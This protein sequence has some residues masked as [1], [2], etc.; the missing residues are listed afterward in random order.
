MKKSIFESFCI[1]VQKGM[2]LLLAN[3]PWI[4]WGC[5]ILTMALPIACLRTRWYGSK[6]AKHNM[7]IIM[8]VAF[9]V[10]MLT[11]LGC[12][13][14]YEL[15]T[16]QE[17]TPAPAPTSTPTPSPSLS[18]LDRF[19]KKD[20]YSR[21]YE[22]LS[23]YEN[24]APSYYGMKGTVEVTEET[25][26]KVKIRPKQMSFLLSEDGKTLEIDTLESD[27]N[28]FSVSMPM[29]ESIYTYG[30]FEVP[31]KEL[32][33]EMFEKKLSEGISKSIWANRME[34]ATSRAY[35][36]SIL[37][38]QRRVKK[39]FLQEM[40]KEEDAFKEIENISID[41]VQFK[42]NGKMLEVKE[43][44]IESLFDFGQELDIGKP[45]E[46][47]SIN[48]YFEGESKYEE[49]SSIFDGIKKYR[50]EKGLNP[51]TGFSS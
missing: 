40:I 47:E 49:Y 25:Q 17:E 44:D 36:L 26:M 50:E 28:P 1:T 2:W 20:S 27:Y 21:E 3:Y 12:F 4:L 23:S 8:A 42:K 14:G 24:T 29:G 48:L 37:E 6:K 46:E 34:L 35:Q 19:F 16:T 41:G 7:L 31:K 45:S 30:A 39:K 13:Y 10:S 43:V 32:S 51:V 33:W 22:V 11:N 18:E 5:I 9:F 15:P 38:G